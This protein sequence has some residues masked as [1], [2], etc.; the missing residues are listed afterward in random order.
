MG[1]A[2]MFRSILIWKMALQ[3]LKKQRR[4]TLLSIAGG[5]IGAMLVTASMIFLHS[6]DYSGDQ[7]LKKHFGNIDWELKP[8]SGQTSFNREETE[9]ITEFLT[10]N[11]LKSLPVVW[12]KIPAAKL[13]FDKNPVGVASNILVIGFDFK[14][15]N[16]FEPELSNV[17]EIGLNND[18]TIVSEAIASQLSLNVGD[19]I[20]LKPRE[21][22]SVLIEV[23]NIVK[24]RGITGYRGEGLSNGT[25]IV[26]LETARRLSQLSSGHFSS[27]FVESESKSE[28]YL[29][30]FPVISSKGNFIIDE[31]K[32]TAIMKLEMMKRSYGMTFV[33]ASSIAILAGT[34]LMFQI[35]LML[36]DSRRETYGILRAIGLD[37][38]KIRAIF[39]VETTV[40]NC[41]C[42]IIGITF[43]I[44]L[45]YG[46]ISYFQKQFGSTLQKVEGSIV[47]ILP[48]VSLNSILYISLFIFLLLFV[49]SF[50][51]SW[52][53]AR[54]NIIEALRG[55][56]KDLNIGKRS[57]IKN[58]ILMIFSILIFSTHIYQFL[59]G[60]GVQH[61][62][63]L[64]VSLTVEGILVFLIWI[65][66][67][68]AALYIWLRIVPFLEKIISP[69]LKLLGYSK[70]VTI[71]ASRY[72]NLNKK[73][74]Y[75]VSYLFSLIFLVLTVT[76]ITSS[77]IFAYQEFDLNNQDILGYPAK[78]DFINEEHKLSILQTLENDSTI[79]ELIKDVNVLKPYMI[80]IDINGI[81]QELGLTLLPADEGYIEEGR[82]KLVQRSARF[83]NDSEAWKALKENKNYVIL[84]QKF[85]IPPSKWPGS[86]DKR[87]IPDRAYQIDERL[88]LTVYSK[89]KFIEEQKK[90][91]NYE[92]Q[93]IG[94]AEGDPGYDF[95]NL[96]FVNPDLFKEN[97]KNGF[98][99]G[100]KSDQG[101]IV[102]NLKENNLLMIQRLEERLASM[103]ISNLHVPFKENAIKNMM[104]KQMVSIYLGFML[105]STLIGLMGLAIIQFRSI[106]ERKKQI[107][108]LRCLG[109]RKIQI[110]Q[111]ILLEGTTISVL[112]LINGLIIG[113]TGGFL[114]TKLFEQNLPP[115][116]TIVNF[117][118]PLFQIL[119]SLSFVLSVSII[120]NLFPGRESVQTMP[121]EALRYVDQ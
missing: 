34:I 28:G 11:K 67:S 52:R 4:I 2:S 121:G 69:F 92:V 26:G 105:L 90:V 88:N 116:Q 27:F 3:N 80:N 47:P 49:Q 101:Y 66:A 96:T 106:M 108:I 79:N 35:M 63:T 45:G 68:G 39:M 46:L 18:E 7:W 82:N 61:L 78:I 89:G 118:Y 53:V 98:L 59:S 6:F 56:T 17:W 51:V 74:T 81:R 23:K 9:Q 119:A 84:N 87:T 48:H 102:F 109:L 77:Q 72:I 40:L 115:L 13:D 113:T 117:D 97:A 103:G 38:S 120:V 44:F 104:V 57:K 114:L 75:T 41:L 33:L 50:F 29:N 14:A 85:M 91:A 60:K 32:R 24:E 94:F 70:V 25:I 62:N 95:Y 12:T 42:T 8:L 55:E 76:V 86:F 10:S 19:V 15:A 22:I 16:A 43:G 30:Q 54:I 31:Q 20:E 112:G 110:I 5:C 107:G 21:D 1:G 37:K 71:L 73:R 111:M 93:I 64:L 65:L 36:A 99:W 100:N 58:Y 83:Q